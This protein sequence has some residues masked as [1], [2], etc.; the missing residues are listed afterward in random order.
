MKNMNNK[1]LIP[2]I[3]VFTLG[4]H[5]LSIAQ[6]QQSSVAEAF[7]KQLYTNLEQAKQRYQKIY[8]DKYDDVNNKN[9]KPV[10][11]PT[12]AFQQAP[13]QFIAPTQP[14]PAAPQNNYNIFNSNNSSQQQSI[15]H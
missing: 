1:S 9:Y 5:T 13:E 4:Y 8:Q 15:F 3:L 2:L 10:N 6:D 12:G 11:P 7:T 14:A